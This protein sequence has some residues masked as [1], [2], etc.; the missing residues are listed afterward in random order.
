MTGPQHYREAEA[1]LTQA[2]LAAARGDTDLAGHLHM[3]A[4]THATLAAAAATVESIDTHTGMLR[5][6]ECS[7][8]RCTRVTEWLELGGLTP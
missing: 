7:C 5:P 4:Q 8:P 3:Q 6:W 1:L 2:R